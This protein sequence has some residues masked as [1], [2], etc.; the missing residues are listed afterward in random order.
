M[1]TH[2]ERLEALETNVSDIQEGM[3]KLFMELQRLSESLNS[4]GD[5]WQRS[6]GQ[7]R[8]N[9]HSGMEGESGRVHSL[10]RK[11]RLEFPRYG[12][13]D[14]TEWLNRVAYYFEYLDVP[15]QEKV[16][17]AA[18]YMEGKAHQWWQWLRRIHQQENRVITW[19]I[20][21][22]EL[23]SRFGP[24][25]GVDFNEALKKLHQTGSLIQ[26]QEEFERL[27]NR[28]NGW[29]KEALMGAFMGGLK[30][31]I[32]EAVRMFRPR[33]LKDAISLARMKDDQ[34][35]RLQKSPRSI[36]SNRPSGAVREQNVNTPYK[37][38]SWEEMQKRRAQGLCF[39]CDERFTSG[40][41]C[42]QPQL[43]LLEIME[44]DPET[45]L[46]KIEE[47]A[48]V[49]IP[50]ITLHA[51]TGWTVNKTM[52]I[53][54]MVNGREL[55]ILVHSGSTHNFIRDKVSSRLK[56][57][58]SSIKPFNVKVASGEPFQCE[59][60]FKNVEVQIKNATFRVTF[61]SLPLIGIDVVLGMQWLEELGIVVCDWRNLAMMFMWENQVHVLKGVKSQKAHVLSLEVMPPK[62]TDGGLP[63]DLQT[64]TKDDRAC[65]RTKVAPDI[66]RL[67]EAYAELFQEPNHLPPQREIEHR[68][69]LKEGTDTVN[70]RPYRYAHFQ[71]EE[72]ERQVQEMLQIG[73]IRPSTSPYSSPVLLVKKKDDSWRFCTDYRAL[74]SATIKDGFPI[75]TIE[76]T[77]DELH[78]ATFVTRLDLRAGYHQVRMDKEDVHKTAFRTHN[79]HYEYL[80]MPFGLCNAPSTFQALMNNLFRPHLRKFIL[81]FF[82][83]ILIYSSGWETHLFHVEQAFQILK[84]HKLYLKFK[85]CAFG[86]QELLYLRHIISSDGVKVDPS[87]IQAML[88]W[89]IPSTISELRGFLGLTG[90]YRKFVKNYGHIARPLTNLLKKWRFS[91]SEEATAAFSHL[92]EAMTTTPTLAMPNFQQPFTIETD[93]AIDGIRAVLTQNNKPIA[94]MSK[95]LGQSKISWSIYAKEM[96]AIQQSIRMW[97]PYLIGQKFFIQTDQKSLKYLLEQKIGTPEQQNWVAKL[98]GYE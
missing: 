68:I 18:Y 62:G 91:W 8:E 65:E 12:G 57:P 24:P 63:F 89:P 50:E 1:A 53:R 21:E 47:N 52:R 70:V 23:W 85:K 83:D 58:F 80:V 59:G 20:F 36:P 41:R 61:F 9:N 78:G 81:V 44:E 98:L 90:Y 71:K 67:T 88:E 28:V 3:G 31:E 55:V 37:R 46:S 22:D 15:E 38:L 10:Q 64:L 33:S 30:M 86:L 29:S 60:K 39:N 73:L 16:T 69:H 19:R 51:L 32:A 11:N 35:Q 79:G 5:V 42:R 2:K 43:L 25:A 27:G 95:A 66:L 40:H 13:D 54:A 94:F 76:D 77:L 26:Y 75:P 48:N 87:K 93:A 34:I 49:E 17:V 7:S 84:K 96:L 45:E 82:D 14:P 74:N 72:I 56:L 97:R 4:R 92:K 6:P